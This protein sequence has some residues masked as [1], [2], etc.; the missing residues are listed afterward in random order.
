MPVD[1]GDFIKV[2][3]EVTLHDGSIAQNVHYFRAVLLTQLP[4]VQALIGIELWIEAAYGNL[5]GSLPATTTQNLCTAQIIEWS[6]SLGRWEVTELIGYFTPTISM[7]NAADE[8]PNQSSAFATFTTARPKSRGRK[9]V[10]PFGEDTQDGT[11]LTAA[12][13]SD[14]VDFADDVLENIVFDVL[15]YFVPG[16]PR[17][18][19]NL[20]LDF[21]GAVITNVLGSQRRRRPGVGA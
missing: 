16:V 2:T 18:A 8:L 21:T 7:V 6:A 17:E 9:F 13:L 12:A 20:F 14:M 19:V 11:Y 1:P 4:N 3:Y 15:E 5:S 10:V